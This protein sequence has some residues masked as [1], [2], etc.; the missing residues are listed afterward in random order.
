MAK[1]K[2]AGRAIVVSSRCTVSQL[3]E[4]AK[5]KPEALVKKEDEKEVYRLSLGTEAFGT[6]FATFS[7]NKTDSTQ[8]A[9]L[10]ILVEP[11]IDAKEHFDDK[12]GSALLNLI[13]MEESLTHVISTIAGLKAKIA[14]CIED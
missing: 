3:R 10:T 1:V 5:Y 14:T 12:Y 8:P 6:K 2:F 4:I 7:D 11:G 13:E 9:T